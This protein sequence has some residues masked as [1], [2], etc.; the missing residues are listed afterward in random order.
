M[1]IITAGRREKRDPDQGSPSR[2][3][4]PAVVLLLLAVGF[5]PRRHSAPASKWP[6]QDRNEADRR[7]GEASSEIPAASWSD[8]LKAIKHD[9]TEH[10]VLAIAAGITFYAILSIFPAIA[11][12]IAIYGLF[13]DP[14]TVASQLDHVAGVLPGGAVDVIRGQM[15][16][17]ASHRN[18]TL[19]LAFVVGLA[20]SLWS[21]NSGAKALFD[22]LNVIY[23]EQEKRGFLRLNAVSLL[24]TLGGIALVLLAL[25]AVVVVPVVLA[26]IGLGAVEDD[27]IRVLRWPCLL[28]IITMGFALLYRYGPSRDRA[29]WRWISWG[30]GFAALA[31]LAASV[32]FSWYAA[33]FGKY[34]ETYGSLGAIVGFMIWIWISA[35]VILTG[36]ELDAEMEHRAARNGRDGTPDR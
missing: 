15:Q 23:G 2:L 29:R 11:A 25:G 8:I 12:L 14:Q 21:A 24:F 32:L 30:S 13:A 22:A 9:F 16:R 17:I 3:W 27:L 7:A 19:G 33:N 18:G 28:V 31:W 20:F 34:N 6:S 36:G 1:T 5:T 4:V 10:R 35:I 26:F